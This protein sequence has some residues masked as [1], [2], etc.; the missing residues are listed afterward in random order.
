MSG[1]GLC[2]IQPQA[3]DQ[4]AGFAGPLVAGVLAD[5]VNEGASAVFEVCFQLV[6]PGFVF[7]VGQLL[8]ER[9]PGGDEGCAQGEVFGHE[10]LEFGARLADV[11][12]ERRRMVH[13]VIGLGVGLQ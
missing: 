4:Y 1:Q 13:D 10:R 2:R 7:F 12:R 11:H 8:T 5:A 9:V 6:L 3:Q